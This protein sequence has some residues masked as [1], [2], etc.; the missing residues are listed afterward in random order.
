MVYR[1]T[2]SDGP[3]V[4]PAAVE[5]CVSTGPAYL[6]FKQLV[7]T[8]LKLQRQLEDVLDPHGLAFSQF[9]AL[10][11]IEA[12]PGI[13][14][15]DLVSHLLVTKGNV[16]ALL[17]RLESMGLVERRPDP[18]DRRANRLHLTGSGATTVRQVRTEHR[19]F[20]DASFKKLDDDQCRQLQSLLRTLEPDPPCFAA[21]VERR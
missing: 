7:I 19:A 17:D 5:P 13:I 3:D 1:L 11:K 10:V 14:Q 12:A 15:Q 20:L 8:F 9:E 16:G 4:S 21:R 18:L 6:A 2:M